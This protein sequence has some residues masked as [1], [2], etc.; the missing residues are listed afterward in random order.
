LPA[1]GHTGNSTV[2]AS[3]RPAK[4]PAQASRIE[5]KGLSFGTHRAEH[6]DADVKPRRF[7][8]STKLS[9]EDTKRGAPEWAPLFIVWCQRL[10]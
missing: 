1:N 9:I 5:L 7:E 4:Y 2:K 3:P 10:W 8:V 6:V